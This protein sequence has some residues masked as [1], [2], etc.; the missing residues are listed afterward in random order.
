MAKAGKVRTPRDPIPGDVEPQPYDR[1]P[2][3]ESEIEDVRLSGLALGGETYHL[4][5]WRYAAFAGC[6]MSGSTWKKSHFTDTAFDDC[7]LANSAYDKCGFERVR[8]AR[9]RMTGVDVS[10]CTLADVQV[11]D[12]PADLSTWRF[13]KLEHAV[14]R[15]CRLT[16]SDWMSASLTRVRFEGCDFADA[17]F[18]HCEMESVTFVGCSFENVRGVAGLSG[19][20]IDRAALIDLTEPM[21]AALGITLPNE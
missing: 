10:G 9:G 6:G 11:L 8:F 5:D 20:A 19:A 4:V 1:G 3:D 12:A 7:D 17:D 16:Q 18:N 15:G 2:D 14:F 21:A 13:A